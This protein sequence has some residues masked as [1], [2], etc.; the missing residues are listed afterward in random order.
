MWPLFAVSVADPLSTKRLAPVASLCTGAPD[1]V[2]VTTIKGAESGDATVVRGFEAAGELT[3]A[4]IQTPW[5]TGS[6][7]EVDMLEERPLAAGAITWHAHEIKT[8]MLGEPVASMKA[9]HSK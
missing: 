3:P 8:I 7:Y 9:D 1:N 5:H 4:T 2:I 6:M